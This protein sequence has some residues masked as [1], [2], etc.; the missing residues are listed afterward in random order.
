MPHPTLAETQTLFWKLISAP[1]GVAK[2]LDALPAVERRAADRLVRKRD[3]LSAV[4]RCDIYANMYF[5]RLRDCV[6]QDFAAVT[7]LVGEVNFHNLM[8]DYLLSHPPSHFSLRYAGQHLPVFLRTHALRQQWPYIADLAELEYAIVDSFDATDAAALTADDLRQVPPE[9]WAGLRLKVSPSVRL[10]RLEWP[11][12]DI[13]SDAKEGKASEAM[14][15]QATHMRIWR[16]DLEVFHKTI[17]A[18]EAA[19]LAALGSDQTFGQVCGILGEGD[20]EEAGAAA[21]FAM[22]QRWLAEE[23]LCR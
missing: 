8:T 3:S 10:L 12:G 7:G 16:R 22:L 21:A 1:E 6:Q 9:D 19:A 4:E 17:D 5:Y 11:V 23:V 2:G 13:W 18:R 14:A 20:D 15:A